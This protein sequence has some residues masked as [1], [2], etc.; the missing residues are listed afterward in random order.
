[1]DSATLR[2]DWPIGPEVDEWVG[3][4]GARGWVAFKLKSGG[5]HIDTLEA[6]GEA[7]GFSRLVGVEM[8]LD[9]ALAALC[10]A[11]DASVS[12][13]IQASQ[14]YF[15]GTDQ[16][17]SLPWKRIEPHDQS[18]TLFRK[19]IWGHL[20]AEVSEYDVAGVVDAVDA[21][22]DT[23][24]AALGWLEELRRLR[25]RAVHEQSL[26][27]H[28][29]V[30]VGVVDRTDWAL[31]VVSPSTKDGQATTYRVEHPARYLRAA[32]RNL[33]ELTA[34]I[35]GLADHLCPEGSAPE[36]TNQSVTIHV[37]P[38]TASFTAL[39]PEVNVS[40]KTDK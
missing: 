39:A 18:W 6:V 37:P 5:F 21:A 29:H 3:A 34:R 32:Q 4:S 23:K 40:A 25:N 12:G 11:F 22:L 7:R 30:Q 31:S 33:T 14:Q 35:L 36:Q 2:V 38:A 13:L 27:R 9:A 16:G 8:S 1:M 19:L 26:P 20:Q 17:N 28:I 24:G 10:G 15:A